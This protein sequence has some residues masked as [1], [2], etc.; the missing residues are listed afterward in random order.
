[1]K[2]TH[3]AFAALLFVVAALCDS[4]SKSGVAF[5][6]PTMKPFFDTK[7][8]SCHGSGGVA[9]SSWK[10]DAKDYEGSI[11]THA[12]HIYEQVYM[13]KSMPPSGLDSIQLVAFKNWYDSG[14]PA[15]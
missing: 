10:Y 2:K 11:K 6:H 3:F 13:T 14:Y 4:C 15:K 5:E 7:C 1:M 8:A 12:D 9:V